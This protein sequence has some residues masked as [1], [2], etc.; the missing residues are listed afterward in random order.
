[1]KFEAEQRGDTRGLWL[2]FTRLRA[3]LSVSIPDSWSH[4]FWTDEN[5]EFGAIHH[6]LFSLQ[7]SDLELGHAVTLIILPVRCT[8]AWLGNPYNT[9]NKLYDERNRRL[10]KMRDQGIIGEHTW[11]LPLKKQPREIRKIERWYR[12]NHRRLMRQDRRD[13]N[14]KS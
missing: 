5:Q 2:T 8:L 14:A 4:F 9:L 10:L 6:H 7:V 11:E 3:I 12:R 13:R 1:M